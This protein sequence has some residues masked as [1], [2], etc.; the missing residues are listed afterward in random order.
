M[1][2]LVQER[3]GAAAMDSVVLGAAELVTDLLGGRLA[4]IYMATI[5]I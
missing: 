3:L 2:G 1:L 4:G 5:S